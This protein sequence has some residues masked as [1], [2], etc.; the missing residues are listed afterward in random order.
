MK[1]VVLGKIIE[2]KHVLEAHQETITDE[3]GKVKVVYTAKPELRKKESI[4]EWKEIC[5]FKGKPL[6]NTTYFNPHFSYGQSMCLNVSE[7]EEVIVSKQV[8][9]ADLEEMHLFTNKIL[10]EIDVNAVDAADQLRLHIRAFNNQMIESNERMKAYCDL[11]CLKYEDSDCEKVFELIYP[12]KTYEIINGK[13][14]VKHDN[15]SQLKAEKIDTTIVDTTLASK[16]ACDVSEISAR[17]S[18]ISKDVKLLMSS[19]LS[20]LKLEK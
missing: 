14:K 7:N 3:N 19:P 9:R 12:S 18:S 13:M 4:K 20:S 6:Y 11:H 16:Y 2:I 17:S 10:E 15:R 8:F 1:S 5:R